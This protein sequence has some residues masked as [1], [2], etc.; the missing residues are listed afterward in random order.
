MMA[1]PGKPKGS[2]EVCKLKLPPFARLVTALSEFF[3][4]Q[5]LTIDIKDSSI[6]M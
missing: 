1:G 6:H 2:N 4:L 3:G 5:L